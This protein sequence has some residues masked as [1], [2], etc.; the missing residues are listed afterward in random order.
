[1]RRARRWSLDGG[2]ASRL[3]L[4]KISA[5]K[6]MGAE[7]SGDII[8]SEAEAQLGIDRAQLLLDEAQERVVGTGVDLGAQ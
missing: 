2:G 8:V 1:M 4:G 7:R 6:A 5:R 3:H